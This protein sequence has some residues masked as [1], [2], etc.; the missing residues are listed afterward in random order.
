[1]SEKTDISD[2]LII[3][4]A[5]LMLGYVIIKAISWVG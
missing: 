4:A 3:V 2:I 5:I 1:M